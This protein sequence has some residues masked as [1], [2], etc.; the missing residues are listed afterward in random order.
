MQTASNVVYGRSGFHST[1]VVWWFHSKTVISTHDCSLLPSS[2]WLP[3]D[4]TYLPLALSLPAR[5]YL[6]KIIFPPEV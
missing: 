4:K 3:L 1:A 6:Y 2:G 5:P